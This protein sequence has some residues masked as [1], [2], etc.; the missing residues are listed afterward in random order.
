[1]EDGVTMSGQK[2]LCLEIRVFSFTFIFMLS[3][4][5]L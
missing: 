2:Q 1:M 4:Q 3:S 5:I